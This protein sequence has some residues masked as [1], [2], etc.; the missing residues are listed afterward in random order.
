M[1]NALLILSGGI[2]SVTLLYDR[3]DDIAAA[4]SFDYGNNYNNREI[5][6]AEYHC[7]KLGILHL[8][9]PLTFMRNNFSSSLF[10]GASAIPE[11]YYSDTNMKSTA[12][13]FLNGIML[14][15]AAGIA[16][17]R[18]LSRVI[19]AN[20]HGERDLYPDCRE[21][22]IRNMS[23]AIAEGTYIG[24]TVEAPYTDV[25]RTDIVRRGTT[26]GIDYRKTWSCY[27]GES[28]HCGKCASCLLRKA[29]FANAGIDDPTEYSS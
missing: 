3:I 17:S 11:G 12:V 22:F 26:L 13:P 5:P 10:M 6:F 2:D 4:V 16:E 18:G 7:K 1:K 20:H 9:I 14:A 24:I 29:S 23:N 28:I 21:P 15:V 19:M 27:K 25:P 8:V